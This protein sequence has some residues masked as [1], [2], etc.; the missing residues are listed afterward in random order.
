MFT[1]GTEAGSDQGGEVSGGASHPFPPRAFQRWG[2]GL[3]VGMLGGFSRW[4]EV[5]R[6]GRSVSG[7]LEPP[8][9]AEAPMEAVA[10]L[11]FL[12]LFGVQFPCLAH[13]S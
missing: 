6:W 11:S 8:V 3:R 5:Q 12:T 10:F 13:F 4:D 9:R 7:R 1:G 2:P